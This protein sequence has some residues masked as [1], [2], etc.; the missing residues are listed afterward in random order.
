LFVRCFSA[1]QRHVHFAT[2]GCSV[3]PIFLQTFEFGIDFKLSQ[4]QKKIIFELLDFV[5]TSTALKKYVIPQDERKF[6][7]AKE[8]TRIMKVDQLR[9]GLDIIV[10]F[11]WPL[12]SI[13]FG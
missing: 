12:L 11:N 5:I 7:F 4:S 2:L 13:R 1:E 9:L 3:D 8:A 6:P 10:Q